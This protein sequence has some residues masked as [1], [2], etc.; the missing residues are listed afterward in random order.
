MFFQVK[1]Q[2]VDWSSENG[3][4]LS[5]SLVLSDKAKKYALATKV[6]Q[7]NSPQII[8]NSLYPCI[9]IIFAYLMA[10]KINRRFDLIKKP[11]YVRGVVYS[12]LSL[13]FYGY[14][15]MLKDNTDIYYESTADEN[16]SKINNE[17]LEGGIE[18][19]SKTLQRNIAFRNL[20]GPEGEKY[21][22]SSGN[23]VIFIRT[24]R[25]PLTHRKTNLENRKEN[26]NNFNIIIV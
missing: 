1:H 5:D 3:Q 11:F 8:L 25:L 9:S 7:L 24:K 21:Y 6:Y 15:S 4:L 17:Y 10:T 23:E 16:I 12:L 26:D 14:Y 19:L 22:T 2:S 13:L 18:F 20:L